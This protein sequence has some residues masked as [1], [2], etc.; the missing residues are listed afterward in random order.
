MDDCDLIT[1]CDKKKGK[2]KDGFTGI[3]KSISFH[4][5]CIIQSK[6]APAVRNIIL[7]YVE[8]SGVTV[9]DSQT[10]KVEYAKKQGLGFQ[11]SAGLKTQHEGIE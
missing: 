10:T 2:K 6:R 4:D 8:M 3:K 9:K 7:V 1:V 11:K 5:V